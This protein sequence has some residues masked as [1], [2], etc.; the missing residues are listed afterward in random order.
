MTPVIVPKIKDDI[1]ATLTYFDAFKYPLTQK[2]IFLF[3]PNAYSKE[4]LQLGLCE[5]TYAKTIFKLREYYSLRNNI[6]L[7]SRRM[8][9][10]S[11]AIKL[12]K[13]ADKVARI[14]S[15]FPYVRG[16]AVSG[17]LSKYF[18]DDNSDIDFFIITATNRLWI[19]RSFTHLLKKIS[20]LIKKQHFFCMNYYIDEC[21]S[22]IIEKNI[23]TATEVVTLMPLKGAIAFE[24]FYRVNKWTK[25]FLPNHF[26]RISSATE[27]K[28]NVIKELIELLLNNRLGNV[29]DNFLMHIT[30]KRWAA[31]T[32]ACKLNGHGRVMCMVADK[33]YSKPDPSG[34]QIKIVENYKKK[35]AEIIN[36]NRTT[37]APPGNNV[38]L[39][40]K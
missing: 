30:A 34:L 26:M 23:F 35:S 19:A 5:L 36:A 31:K 17:S 32:R 12:L 20:F 7:I 25:N 11:K 8:E 3:L 16:V 13:T 33:H 2:E 27:I 40:N 22:E 29:L 10:Y 15:W 21:R 39:N 6:T 37:A 4:E 24:D 1:L 18:A 38:M 28:T 14:L 9:G